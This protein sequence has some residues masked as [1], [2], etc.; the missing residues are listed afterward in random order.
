MRILAAI[1]AVLLFFPGACF[2]FFGIALEGDGNW[3]LL[4]VA[5]AIFAVV[6]FLGRYGF[7]DER[8]IL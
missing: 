2:A 5:V 1:L 7:S 3:P 6:Y 8:D 4:L